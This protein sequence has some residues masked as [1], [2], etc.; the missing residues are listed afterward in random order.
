MTLKI[1]P[2]VAILIMAGILILCFAL[3]KGCKNNR[4]LVAA[5]TSLLSV[6]KNLRNVIDSSQKWNDSTQKDLHDTLDFVQGQYE[7]VNN[8]KERVEADLD[9][10]LKDN[11][12]LIEKHNIGKYIDT[13]ATTVPHEYIVDCEDCFTK[14]QNTTS[15]SLKYK[16][17]YNTL[18]TNWDRQNKIYS[19]GLKKMDAE[20]TSFFNKINLLTKQQQEAQEKLK[21]KGK[22]YLSWGVLWSPWPVAGGA[23]L[24]YQTKENMIY[25]AKWYY[26]KN[27]Q[28]IETTLNFPLS[29]RFK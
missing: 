22:L 12:A 19:D 10:A 9:K 6:N 14:L 7:L 24:L 29:L 3:F 4:Q 13:T 16:N 21:P 5:N 25:G 2:I 26:G 15:L 17:D 28:M 23:G 1:N 27:G 20:R 8:Q 18:Q 11:A